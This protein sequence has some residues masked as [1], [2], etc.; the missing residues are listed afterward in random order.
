M[1]NLETGCK[2][3]SKV[4]EVL[5]ALDEIVIEVSEQVS[6]LEITLQN[7]LTPEYDKNVK[8]AEVENE[9]V[10]C[11]KIMNRLLILESK[12]KKILYTVKDIK[13]RVEI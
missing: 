1:N 4:D 8:G 10:A 2:K 9:Q 11:S 7:I 3:V 13:S 6:G 5:S 12:I